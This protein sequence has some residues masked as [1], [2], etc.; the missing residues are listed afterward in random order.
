[1]N[2]DTNSMIRLE[3]TTP[4]F[5]LMVMDVRILVSVSGGDTRGKYGCKFISR[6]VVDIWL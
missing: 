6:D 5:D 3:I 2:M 4:V 1:M